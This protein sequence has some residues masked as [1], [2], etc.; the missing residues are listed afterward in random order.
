MKAE[1]IVNDEQWLS[2]RHDLLVKEK[3]FAR[4]SDEL[5]QARRE[6][7]WRLIDKEYVF[8]GRAG[9]TDLLSLFGDHDQLIVQ[10]FMFGPETEEGCPMC[11]FWADGYDPMITHIKQRAA[12]FVVVSRG[13]LERLQAYK[14]RMGW[15]FEW[16]SSA[17]NDFNFGF[18]VS[19]TEEEMQAGKTYYNFP[20]SAAF[21]KEMPGTSVFARNGEQVYHT[22][23]SFSRGMDRLNAAY[24]YIDLLPKG[25]DEQDLPY[26]MAW[27]KRHDKY[28]SP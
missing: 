5:A 12:A 2:Q 19:A 28:E 4:L 16:V 14:Q 17:H 23:S 1:N 13:P 21:S 24:A 27:V 18:N 10:H 9:K 11:S 22:Y 8:E 7:G 25:R 15:G 3:D 26:P 6:L 20:E